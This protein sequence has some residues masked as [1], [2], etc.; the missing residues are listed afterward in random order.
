MQVPAR[1]LGCRPTVPTLN[2]LFLLVFTIT[3]RNMTEVK[4]VLGIL[5]LGLAVLFVFRIPKNWQSQDPKASGKLQADIVLV[6][7]L[8]AS[9]VVLLRS[10]ARP[11]KTG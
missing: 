4:R 3:P 10:S 2:G 11:P 9:G 7:V 6:L 5:L 8:G 1:P